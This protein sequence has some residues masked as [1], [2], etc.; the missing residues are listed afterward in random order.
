M[1]D[2][3]NSSGNRPRWLLIIAGALVLIVVCMATAVA[4]FGAGRLTATADSVVE[5]IIVTQQPES[6]P[7]EVTREVIVTVLSDPPDQTASS[8]GGS[9]E[10]PAVEPEPALPTPL[11]TETPVPLPLADASQDIPDFELY[12]EVWDLIEGRFDGELPSGEDVLYAAIQGSL[13]EL[14]DVHTRFVPSDVA[15]RLRENASGS[16]SGIGAYVRQNEDGFVE[17]ISPISGLPA[18]VAGILPGDLVVGVDG[19]SVIGFSLDEV[20]LLVRGPEGTPVTLTVRREGSEEEFEFTVFRTEFE[21]ARVITELMSEGGA[22]IAYLR[23]TEFNQVSA[24][25]VH[26]ALDELLAQQPEGLILDLRNNPGGFLQQTIQIADLFLPEGVV[27]LERNNRG[28][29]EALR[30]TDGDFGEDIPMVVLINSGSA[31]A[32]EVV[33]GAIQDRDRGVIIGETSF[34]KGSVQSVY[35]LSEGS[36]LRVTI[37]RWFTP[38]N[39]QIDGTGITPDIVV[40]MDPEVLVGSEEDVQLVRALEY[41]RKGN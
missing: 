23:L 41:M 39:R 13:E 7:V 36:E 26:V 18:D 20:V 29:D 30:S 15:E 3:H 40:E 19:D 33:A 2:D 27:L 32:S 4:S 1:S 35:R 31:S 28:L 16:I 9:S 6:V 10:E 25:R 21:V 5:T 8:E 11:P 17:I 34:G 24:E 22:P 37:A 38:L 12:D 14:E